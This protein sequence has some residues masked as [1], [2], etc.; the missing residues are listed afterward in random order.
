MLHK[1]LKDIESIEDF[2]KIIYI[3][4]LIEVNHY[5]ENDVMMEERKQ[6][7]AKAVTLIMLKWMGSS[8]KMNRLTLYRNKG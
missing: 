3:C 8:T 5:R 7:I 1:L 6:A 4:V 2:F